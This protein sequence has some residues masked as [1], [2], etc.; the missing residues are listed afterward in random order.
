M[1]S[2]HLE[3]DRMI[4]VLTAASEDTE[5]LGHLEICVSCNGEYMLLSEL[6]QGLGDDEVWFD[7]EPE[8]EAASEAF[9]VDR[10]WRHLA[11]RFNAESERRSAPGGNSLS[12]LEAI[13][14]EARKKHD[15]DANESLSMIDDARAE[16]SAMLAE[17]P[18]HVLVRIMLARAWKERSNALRVLGEYPKALEALEHADAT[19]ATVA[20][21]AIDRGSHSYSRALVL[22][23]MGQL[24]RAVLSVQSAAAVF[25]DYGD[26]RRHGHARMLEAAI[27]FQ[28]GRY[29]E[30]RDIFLS[31]LKETQKSGDLDATA[32]IFNNL[33]NCYMEAGDFDSANTYFL[34]AMHLY[35][36]VGIDNERIR[37]R[38]SLGRMLLRAGQP[39]DGLTRLRQ[40]QAEFESVSQVT[41]AALVALDIA[42]TLLNEG[43]Y[44]AVVELTQRI[45]SVLI[46]AEMKPSVIQAVEYLTEAS[47]KREARPALA[48]AIRSYL[49]R[50]PDEPGIRFDPLM[51]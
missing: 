6:H 50:L 39:E 33:A 40:A 44:E 48:G 38:W 28:S 23:K 3:H 22:F 21:A 13:L 2:A 29:R 16:L 9:E 51:N 46:N 41:D 18:S 11:E 19:V 37:V 24:E 1:I 7:A 15:Q 5:A 14:A 12:S 36:Q 27:F 20:S 47:K 35:G 43:A 49:E 10:S 42:E 25:L 31:V 8:F 4:D 17:D 30:A 45:T 26:M 34:Q 32:R